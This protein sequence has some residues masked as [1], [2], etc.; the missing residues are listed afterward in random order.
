MSSFG[1]RDQAFAAVHDQPLAERVDLELVVRIL[2]RV[3]RRSCCGAVP[4]SNTSSCGASSVSLVARG[5]A[6]RE[7][8]QLVARRRGLELHDVPPHGQARRGKLER[9]GDVNI[10]T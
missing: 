1:I 9:P 2:Q 3:L 10:I 7:H 6:A 8:E 4:P 5:H